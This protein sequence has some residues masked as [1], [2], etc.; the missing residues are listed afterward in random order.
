[1]QNHRP[2]M[3]IASILALPLALLGLLHPISATAIPY[4]PSH[5]FISPSHNDSLAYLMLTGN[6]NGQDQATTAFLSMN[7]S[8]EVDAGISSYTTLL[9]QVPFRGGDNTAAFVPVIDDHGIIKVYTGDCQNVADPGVVWQFTPDP[10]SAIGNGTW[11]RLSVDKKDKNT[12]G[13]NYLAAGFTY[14]ITD[15]TDSAVYTFGGM[16]PWSNE[17]NTNWVAA[18]NYSHD[19][20]LLDPTTDRKTPYL[21]ESAGEHAPPIAEAGFSITPLLPAY[22]ATADGKMLRQQDFLFIGG[23][24]EKAFLNMSELA[25]YSLPHDSWSFVAIDWSPPSAKTELAVRDT[26]GI[27]EPRSG[28]T[29]VLSPDGDKVIVV[30][31]WV[32]NTSVSARPQLAILE[33]GSAYGGYG[34]WT[35]QV[36]SLEDSFLSDGSGIYGHGAAMLPG[37]IMMI[38]GGYRASQMSKR[39][40]NSQV[41]FYNVTSNSWATSYTNPNWEITNGASQD[42]SSLSKAAKIG[43]GVGVSVG[44]VILCAIGWTGW[45]YSRRFRWR[46]KR[47]SELR[48]LALG[49][50]RSHFWGRDD[51][52]MASSIHRPS[53]NSDRSYPWASNTCNG[54]SKRP[55]EEDVARAE[56]TGLLLDGL[57]SAK[58]NRQK[59]KPSYRFSGSNPTGN[60]HPIDEREEDEVDASDNLIARDPN[61]TSPQRGLLG[62][63]NIPDPH[64][65]APFLTPQTTNAE[66]AQENTR[67]VFEEHAFL[68]RFGIDD[69]STGTPASSTKDR[70]HSSQSS[71]PGM[72]RLGNVRRSRATVFYNPTSI[73]NNGQFPNASAVASTHSKETASAPSDKR[74]SSDS[75]STAYTS[76]SQKQ[77]EGE[78]LLQSEPKPVSPLEHPTKVA[79]TLSQPKGPKSADW[80]GNVRRVLS[81]SRKWTTSDKHSSSD[82][83]TLS[84]PLTSGLDR[85]KTVLESKRVSFQEPDQ[86]IA[87]PRRAVSASAE[88]FR[89]KQGAEDWGSSPTPR[90]SHEASESDAML[91]PNNKENVQSDEEDW[92]IEAAAEGRRV[93]VT[94]TVPKEQ[95][96]VVNAMPGDLE[97]VSTTTASASRVTS[98]GTGTSFRTVST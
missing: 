81:G 40:T 29:A 8:Q 7:I 48:K 66:R 15:T 68:A 2:R 58:N 33:V 57:S 62:G 80:I 72:M 19:M 95:L 87:T 49:A 63:I 88:L 71:S 16:C 26:K 61:P 77:A 97:S 27:I 20:M 46:R 42:S 86:G 47:N 74:Y 69:G 6:S 38:S 34:P 54:K 4:T 1:M 70:P 55:E 75:Y 11:E 84:T 90:T 41:Y 50:Q 85:R 92:D 32:G 44:V 43:I 36:P 28:H 5:V 64:I 18:A 21:F 9:D 45:K 76:Q 65:E 3:K 12:Y 78:H 89:R 23:Q 13:P 98:G 73:P 35:W 25:V 51:P 56:M 53:L 39:S 94:F 37:G 96:R 82:D 17:T 60:I 79:A 30:G 31:G 10:D 93:Q 22:S 67:A 52:E 83:K 91:D 14:E 59:N 24:T